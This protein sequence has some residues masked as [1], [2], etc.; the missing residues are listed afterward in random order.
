MTTDTQARA[1][2]ALD[3]LTDTVET[4]EAALPQL[5]DDATDPDGVQL[6]ALLA[7]VRGARERLLTMERDLERET[8]KAMSS[9]L[10]M[11]DGQF[12]VERRRSKDRTAWDH[13]SWTRDA[14]RNVLRRRG[15]LGAAG[16]VTKDGEVVEVSLS[17]LLSDVEAI[18][19]K[20]APRVGAMRDLGLDPDDYCETKSGHPRVNILP[21]ADET[22]GGNDE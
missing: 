18:H 19:G 2:G 8:A 21:L 5:I 3:E 6:A 7:Q 10:L 13:D 12:R 17:E 15:V 11:V 4:L 1:A 9:D 22:E 20:G 16:V 14:R